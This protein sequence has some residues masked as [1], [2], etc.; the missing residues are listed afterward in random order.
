M[1]Y[2]A[3]THGG[4]RSDPGGKPYLPPSVDPI[5][6]VYQEQ[7]ERG[8]PALRRGAIPIRLPT[9]FPSQRATRLLPGKVEAH[10][11]PSRPNRIAREPS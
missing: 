1:V 10:S 6:K 2:H 8:E 7:I 11:G 5:G 9:E 4:W 3:R